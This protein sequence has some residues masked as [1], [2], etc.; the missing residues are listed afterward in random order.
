MT[1]AQIVHDNE[2]SFNLSEKEIHEKVRPFWRNNCC[3][4]FVNIPLAYENMGRYGRMYTYRC[5][6]E[7]DYTSWTTASTTKSAYA[8]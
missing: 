7:G 3:A 8:L 4:I 6:Y 2:R 5:S 1:I